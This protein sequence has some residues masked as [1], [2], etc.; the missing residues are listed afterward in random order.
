MFVLIFYIFTLAMGFIFQLM[1]I[2]LWILFIPIEILLWA[3]CFLF[4]HNLM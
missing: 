4:A 2:L 1:K 3:F